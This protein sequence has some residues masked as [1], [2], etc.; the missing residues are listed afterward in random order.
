MAMNPM[1]MTSQELR[2]TLD[3]PGQSL[4]SYSLLKTHVGLPCSTSL[5]VHEY[6]RRCDGDFCGGEIIRRGILARMMGIA[7][8]STK[9][10][11][12]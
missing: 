1:K 3:G 6:M 5:A 4:Q 11:P 10:W 12:P 7:R 8:I 9:C 2:M